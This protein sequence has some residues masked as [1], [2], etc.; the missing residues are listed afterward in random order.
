MYRSILLLAFVPLCSSLLLAQ[1]KPEKAGSPPK[2]SPDRSGGGERR[3][4]D[5]PQASRSLMEPCL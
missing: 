3:H 1:A 2:V 5:G 4:R